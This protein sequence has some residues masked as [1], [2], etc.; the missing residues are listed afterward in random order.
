MY[1]TTDVLCQLRVMW[2]PK[3]SKNVRNP[4]NNCPHNPPRETV[5]VVDGPH[6][7]GPLEKT[8]SWRGGA[9]GSYFRGCTPG[10]ELLK[11]VNPCEN[12]VLRS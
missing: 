2:T 8:A 7:R 5:Y 12:T 6:I 11:C 9:G 4:Y 3:A 1:L 10:L